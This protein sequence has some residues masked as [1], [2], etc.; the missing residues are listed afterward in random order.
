[1]QPILRPLIEEGE[2]KKT[3]LEENIVPNRDELIRQKLRIDEKIKRF[4]K[5]Q[6]DEKINDSL[7]KLEDISDS[8][9]DLQNSLN[10]IWKRTK[11]VEEEL[12]EA[13]S[14]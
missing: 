6:I 4:D 3:S 7:I 12:K 13:L 8:V 5:K 10:I 11:Q 9:S 2:D 1:M 14:L